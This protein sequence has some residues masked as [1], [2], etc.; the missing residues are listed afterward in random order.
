MEDEEHEDEDAE[1]DEL[2]EA[3]TLIGAVNSPVLR[4]LGPDC[5]PLSGATGLSYEYGLLTDAA[6]RCT[7]GRFWLVRFPKG[8]RVWPGSGE[9]NAFRFRSGPAVSATDESLAVAATA[10]TAAAA[11]VRATTATCATAAT[12]AAATAAT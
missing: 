11:S 1:D 3:G 9:D 6:R 5:P 12:A 8:E 2:F 7:Q 4:N 10:T